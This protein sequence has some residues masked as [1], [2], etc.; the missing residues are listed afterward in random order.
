MRAVVLGQIPDPY[1]STTVTTDNLT[2]V[3]MDHNI[4]Y[5]AA[6]VVASLDS[7]RSRLPD[8]D[9]SV[10]GTSNHPFALAV[11]RDAGDIARVAFKREQ[12]VWVCRFDVVELDSVVSRRGKVAFVGGYT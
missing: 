8:L 6:V 12:R 9:S 7:S 11:K 4:V 2:L 5:G 1:T 10:L 3:R